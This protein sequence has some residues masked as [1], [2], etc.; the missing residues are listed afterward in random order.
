MWIPGDLLFYDHISAPI[1]T[2]HSPVF[3]FLTQAQSSQVPPLATFLVS[4]TFS[5]N[6]ADSQV[7]CHFSG[8][9]S[10]PDSVQTAG[11]TSQEIYFPFGSQFCEADTDWWISYVRLTEPELVNQY[12]RPRQSSVALEIL[13][14]GKYFSRNETQ[15]LPLIPLSNVPT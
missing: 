11:M 5:H 4:G 8:S 3:C 7:L 15:H 6:W 10:L 2:Q 14:R 9:R 13:W 1:S 12:G